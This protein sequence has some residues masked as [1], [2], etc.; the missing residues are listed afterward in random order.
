MLLLILG[1]ISGLV[2]PPTFFVAGLFTLA[3]LCYLVQISNSWKEAAIMGFIFGFGHFLVGIYWISIGV[4]VYID[5]FW[6]VMPFALFGLPIILA[7]F[8]AASCSCSFLTRNHDFYQFIF[9]L[10]WVFFEWV[11]SW[12]F[13]GL[14][15][16]LLGYAF[17]FSDI[18]IQS[19]NIIGIYGLSFIVIY[20]STSFYPIFSKQYNLLKISLLTSLI[21]IS[22]II[23]YGILRLHNNPTSFSATK[24]RL[25]QPSIPQLAKWDVDE[26]WKNLNLH[27]NLSETPSNIDL[28][29]WSEAAMVVPYNYEPIKTKLLRMLENKQAILVTGGITNNSKKGENLKIYTSLYAL[30]K[31]GEQLFEYHKSHLVPF[32]EYMP[33]KWLLPFKKLTPGF[34]D[35]T[36]GDGK[37]V[38][39]PKPFITIKPLI[40][41]ESIFPTFVRTSNKSADVIINVTNDAWY[42]RSSGPYQHLHISRMRSIENGLP[43]LRTA[44]NGISAII[45]PVGRIIQKSSLNEVSYIDGL[46]PNKLNSETLYSQFGDISA[47]LAILITFISYILLK[48]SMR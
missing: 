30:S 36:E 9:C 1:M 3:F 7:S 14:P 48:I 22:L 25:V 5:E 10:W 12:I 20:I 18:L 29:I 41:Y 2:F 43:M 33:L 4:T 40:C 42:G 23:P 19:A 34:L 15:W 39:L 38:T 8:I 44:N 21:V 6:W 35:Y 11:R 13:T 27:I 31:E 47:L 37:L 26:F 46:L 32:G 24:V 16:N 28:I 17:S 45:D